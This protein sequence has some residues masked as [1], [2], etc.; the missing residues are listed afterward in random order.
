MD[1]ERRL[2]NSD[3]ETLLELLMV[4]HGVASPD[5]DA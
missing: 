2:Y 4:V 3:L 5:R 1:V